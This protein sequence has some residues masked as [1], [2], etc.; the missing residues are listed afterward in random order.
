MKR[1]IL[2]AALATMLAIPAAALADGGH[3]AKHANAGLQLGL[4]IKFDA[5][6]KNARSRVNG[7]ILRRYAE[8]SCK[9]EHAAIGDD[10]FKAKYGSDNPMKACVAALAGTTTQQRKTRSKL[11][12][13]ASGS[14]SG[15]GTAAVGL[16]STISGSP[17]AHGTLA[18]SLTVDTAGAKSNDFGGSCAAATG[19]VT[20]TDSATTTNSLT[21]SVKGKLCEVGGT[22]ASAG[23]VFFGR[24]EVTGGSGAFSSA[25]GRGALGFYQQ[26]GGTSASAFEF[27]SI[28]S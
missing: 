3:G 17:I 2:F 6:A 9:A 16:T 27:G 25:T 12:E 18:S 5:H 10:A 7:G 14:V 1:L 19:T 13:L 8:A 24:Y 22:G 11:V 20:L 26:A 15:L 28:G 21:E 23:H 4:A